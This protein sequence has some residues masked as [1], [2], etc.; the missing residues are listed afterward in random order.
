VSVLLRQPGGFKSGFAIVE[1]LQADDLS[2]VE[3]PEVL[4]VETDFYA[5]LVPAGPERHE[6]EYLVAR[7]DQFVWF[8]R[9]L[10]EDGIKGL[11]DCGQALAPTASTR[12][13]RIVGINELELLAHKVE[14]P[15]PFAAIPR[16][17][18]SS[19]DLHV[20]PRHRPRSIPQAQE[21]A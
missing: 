19:H 3:R 20:L 2:A 21:S 1:P 14:R 12:L 7:V 15:L 4:L 10:Y 9:I 6:G 8:V 16:L 5:A 18:S 13:D 17:V 11:D